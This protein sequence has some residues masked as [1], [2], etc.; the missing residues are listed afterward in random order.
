MVLKRMIHTALTSSAWPGFAFVPELLWVRA[1]WPPS[2]SFSP[3]H[4]R[5][6]WTGARQSIQTQTTLLDT[7]VHKWWHDDGRHW[8]AVTSVEDKV[9]KQ[10]NARSWLDTDGHVG[11]MDGKKRHLHW[12]NKDG[13]QMK[14]EWHGQKG[15]LC[16]LGGG[17]ESCQLVQRLMKEGSDDAQ[18][19]LVLTGLQ[20][21]VQSDCKMSKSCE[22]ISVCPTGEKTL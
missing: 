21:P 11:E 3:L 15:G 12:G 14:S 20:C 2:Q 9:G 8:G 13:M 16:A 4:W 22:S 10:T 7:F 6:R 1:S 5:A 19:R 18:D 17:Q